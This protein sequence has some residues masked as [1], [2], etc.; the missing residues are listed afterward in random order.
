VAAVA[1]VAGG[2]GVARFHSQQ[3]V[4][5]TVH[6][7]RNRSWSDLPESLA[8]RVPVAVLLLR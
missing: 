3:P 1:R 6:Q 8:A 7:I 4:G 2:L 5:L